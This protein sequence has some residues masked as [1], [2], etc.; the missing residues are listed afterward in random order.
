[1]QGQFSSFHFSTLL[2][3]VY[4]LSMSFQSTGSMFRIFG[5]KDEILSLPWYTDLTS[6][7]EN[8]EIYLKLHQLLLFCVKISFRI[9]GDRFLLSRNISL[10]RD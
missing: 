3:K 2:L 7:L 4:K 9:V 6:G 10:A 5:P 1:M 8:L